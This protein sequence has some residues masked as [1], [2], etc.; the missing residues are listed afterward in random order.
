MALTGEVHKLEEVSHSSLLDMYLASCICDFVTSG[1][2]EYEALAKL[3]K[4]F[5]DVEKK[6]GQTF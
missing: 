2:T 4:H 3:A 5:D 1:K 6:R